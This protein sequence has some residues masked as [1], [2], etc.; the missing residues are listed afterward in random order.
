MHRWRK[1]SA[2]L[3]FAV[4]IGAALVVGWKIAL[5]SS[6]LLIIAVIAW[7]VV[8][9]RR[10]ARSHDKD[11]GAPGR[12]VGGLAGQA[13]HL[14]Y[15]QQSLLGLLVAWVLSPLL[16][17]DRSEHGRQRRDACLAALDE[18]LIRFDD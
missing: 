9:P 1:V 14:T 4:G 11:A 3:L 5:A 12:G 18:A 2:P 13:Q 6:V 15:E 16:D 7:D 17:V 10:T 8:R